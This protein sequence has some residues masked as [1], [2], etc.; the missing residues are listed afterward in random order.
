MA[1]SCY[2]V[3]PA[4]FIPAIPYIQQAKLT[5]TY[6]HQ[7]P[8]YVLQENQP[9][10]Y[11]Y[12]ATTQANSGICAEQRAAAIDTMISAAA[13][14]G[15]HSEALFTAVSCLDAYL[16]AQP[17]NAVLLQPLGITCLWLAAKYEQLCVPSVRCFAQFV[18]MPSGAPAELQGSS[19]APQQLLVLLE[20]RVLRAVDYNLARI[21]TTKAFV[22]RIMQLLAAAMQEDTAAAL[23]GGS[24]AGDAATG[25]AAAAA[26]AAAYSQQQLQ[27][28]RQQQY[29][30]MYWL[31][32]YLAEATLLEYHLLSCK[33]S[34]LAAAAFAVAQL[35]LGLKIDDAALECITGHSLASLKNPMQWLVA[36]HAAL[37]AAQSAG[38]PYAVSEIYSSPA[39]L[40][41]AHVAPL[42][43]RDD[44]RLLA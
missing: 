28:R 34:E 41:V 9:G 10:R 15:L 14:L 1:S 38:R 3:S 37:A 33:P 22:H 18:R 11:A 32:S 6:M 16:A 19:T 17:T 5:H 13:A 43:S 42:V 30:Q 8:F 21:V 20:V 39:A 7:I 35:L 26:A 29:S 36:L 12:L 4:S 31:T 40:C 27:Q 23:A 25:T 24:A 2:G 44:P